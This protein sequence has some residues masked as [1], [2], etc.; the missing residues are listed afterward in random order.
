MKTNYLI[1]AAMILCSACCQ[2]DNL[3]NVMLTPEQKA[4]N[5]YAENDS[6]C[7]IDS[8]GDTCMFRVVTRDTAMYIRTDRAHTSERC[9]DFCFTENEYTLLNAEGAPFSFRVYLEQNDPFASWPVVYATVSFS[10]VT[11]G[12]NYRNFYSHFPELRVED[13]DAYT[14]ANG[15]YRDTL[16]LGASS[17]FNVYAIPGTCNTPDSLHCD[18]IFYNK[19][20]GLVGISMSDGNWWVRM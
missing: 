8:Q 18:T 5:P 9:T 7:F 20:Q 17:F 3:G 15:M 12:T 11:S 16:H 10:F 4:I 6:I 14:Q 19:L 13:I 1:F 2:N